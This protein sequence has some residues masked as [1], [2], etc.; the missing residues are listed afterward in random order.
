MTPNKITQ[1][2]AAA[3]LL[4]ALAGPVLAGA[5]S[6]SSASSNAG[7]ASV[8][9]L[10]TSFEHSSQAS[11]GPNR[12]AAGDYKLIEVAQAPDR[13]GM[14]RMKLQALADS[15]TEFFLYLPQQTAEQSRLDAGAVVTVKERPYGF[16]FA[17]QATQEA[18]F[19]VLADDWMRELQT[20]V[21]TL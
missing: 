21:V 10:S 20:K 11:S 8:G 3:A 6:A 1:V 2:A 17:R 14:A 4:L 16:E 13:P 9:S 5:S 18:F 12:T 15:R 7:S 19:L